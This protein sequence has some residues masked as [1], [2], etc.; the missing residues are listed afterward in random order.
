VVR[1]RVAQTLGEVAL[2]SVMMLGGLWVIVNPLGTVGALDMWANE[3]SLGT[4]AAVA[5]GTPSHSGRTLGE[6]MRS[7]FGGAIGG[8][9][10]YMEFGN[11]RWCDDPA[12]L[13]PRLRTAGL[14]IAARE[15]V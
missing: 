13:D 5:T 10:C 7:V 14:R 9:W 1:R 4:L 2:M 3:A 12:R 11:V 8:P 6:S 15:Q